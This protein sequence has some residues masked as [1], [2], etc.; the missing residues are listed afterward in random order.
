MQSPIDWRLDRVP[1]GFEPE[2]SAFEPRE[3]KRERKKEQEGV[4][5]RG[6]WSVG[7]RTGM[8]VLARSASTG[9]RNEGKAGGS[10]GR[11]TRECRKRLAL[12]GATR[13]WNGAEGRT[14]AWPT[15]LEGLARTQRRRWEERI[16]VGTKDNPLYISRMGAGTWA[17]GNRLLFGYSPEQDEELEKVFNYCLDNGINL[18][19]TGDSYGTGKFNGRAEMLLGQFSKRRGI[20]GNESPNEICVATKLAAYPWRLTRKSM[21]QAIKDSVERLGRT[22]GSLELGQMHW[23]PAAYGFQFQEDALLNGLAD[24]YEQG[25]IK[26]V[27]LS[28]Y[29]P[30]SLRSIHKKFAI[31]GVPIGTLQVQFSL[32]SYQDYQREVLEVC[33]QLG[34]TVI[35]YSPLCLGLLSGKYSVEDGGTLPGGPRGFLARQLL[36]EAESSGLLPLMRELASQRGPDTGL[37]QIA[38]GWCIAKNTVPI[39]GARTLAQCRENVKALSTELTAEE[40]QALDFAASRAKSTVQNSMRSM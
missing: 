21:V 5:S 36:P 9:K 28:N 13:R 7:G 33:Q 30:E 12:R 11:C 23:S 2:G 40:V 18:F 29:G 39:P 22:D 17:W 3:T 35:A 16:N 26:A 20:V 1:V 15:W 4:F 25:L 14:L 24:A 19:D 31:R 34:I 6:W 10:R 38:L 8:E 32:L 27:G 37:P